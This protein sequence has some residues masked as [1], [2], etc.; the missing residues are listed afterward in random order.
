[1]HGIMYC[2]SLG[3]DQLLL[4]PSREIVAGHSWFS[5]LSRITAS[6]LSICDSAYSLTMGVKQFLRH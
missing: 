3:L 4:L 6:I 2:V 5:G 1:M